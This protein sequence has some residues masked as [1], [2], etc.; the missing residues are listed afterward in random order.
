MYD[1]R[2]SSHTYYRCEYHFVW[3]PKYRYGVLV[4]KVKPRVQEVLRD[5]CDWLDIVIIE[6]S[7]CVDH[8][9]MYLSVPPKH[10]P[11]YVMKILKGKS[12][13]R[14]L[15]EFGEL[16]KRYWGGRLWSRGYFVSTVGVNK[17]VI[18][19]YIQN[20]RDEEEKIRQ[21]RIWRK[22]V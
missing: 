2:K 1:Y 10:S 21:M 11:S 14:L 18:R 17:E 16:R 20:Q 9:H 7:I 22:G 4:D 5:L 13:E 8:I 15:K 12:A 6:G 3:T 19:R